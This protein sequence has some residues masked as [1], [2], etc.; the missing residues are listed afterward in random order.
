MGRGRKG[1]ELWATHWGNVLGQW[2]HECQVLTEGTGFA[3]LHLEAYQRPWVQCHPWF[4]NRRRVL[5]KK[6]KTFAVEL[7][8]ARPS[9]LLIAVSQPFSRVGLCQQCL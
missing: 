4:T 8:G 9:L 1:A 5:R 3:S 7:L 6:T 2:S